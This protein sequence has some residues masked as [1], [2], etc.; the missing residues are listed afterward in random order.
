MTGKQRLQRGMLSV[1]L[2]LLLGE[3]GKES[4]RIG[5]FRLTS[6]GRSRQDTDRS[7]LKME[8]PAVYA[9][10]IKKVSWNQLA[11][12]Y[13]PQH[14]VPSAPVPQMYAAGLRPH[15]E[16]APSADPDDPDVPF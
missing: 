14:V 2:V 8:H 4:R 6:L 3:T 12:E 15:A 1:A 13:V 9:S 5:S 16:P 10:V 7:V 11:V